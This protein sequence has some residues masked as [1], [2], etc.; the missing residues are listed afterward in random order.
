MAR[1]A[2]AT[3]IQAVGNGAVG[4]L[5]SLKHGPAAPPAKP[6]QVARLSLNRFSHHQRIAQPVGDLG[7]ADAWAAVSGARDFEERSAEKRDAR[8]IG[9]VI[10]RVAVIGDV[11]VIGDAVI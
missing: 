10:D 2:L 5:I 7:E 9:L 6:A 11:V 8:E 4:A 1:I 3:R